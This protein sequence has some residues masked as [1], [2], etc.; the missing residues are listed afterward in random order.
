MLPPR[1]AAEEEAGRLLFRG[2][3]GSQRPGGML[4]NAG[5]LTVKGPANAGL[6]LRAGRL[7]ALSEVGALR[8]GCRAAKCSPWLCPVDR[9][10]GT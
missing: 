3:V 7:L 9:W 2:R 4:A 10:K 8:I 1:Y 5:D 6:A